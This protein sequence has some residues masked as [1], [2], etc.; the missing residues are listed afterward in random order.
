MT[1]NKKNYIIRIIS[2]LSNKKKIS[3]KSG[4][5]TSKKTC[6]FFSFSKPHSQYFP[7]MLT[8]SFP[9]HKKKINRLAI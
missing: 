9:D 7:L 1:L 5:L 8:D 3:D 4:N 6:T 2:L